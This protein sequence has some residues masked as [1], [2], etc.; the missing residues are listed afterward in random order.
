MSTNHTAPAKV[1]NIC[2]VKLCIN[3]TPYVYG[4]SVFYGT[5]AILVMIYAF[6]KMMKE[7]KKLSVKPR[8]RV[9]DEIMETEN[10]LQDSPEDEE[11]ESINNQ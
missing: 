6:F 4:L 7:Y 5:V 2:D 10:P 8:R 9:F 11:I 1:Q 3:P